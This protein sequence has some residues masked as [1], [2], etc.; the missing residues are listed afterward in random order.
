M[1]RGVSGLQIL[2]YYLHRKIKSDIC[3]H[4]QAYSG[5]LCQWLV[6]T[7]VM[8]YGDCLHLVL[9]CNLADL[10]VDGS[11]TANEPKCTNRDKITQRWSGK[12]TCLGLYNRVNTNVAEG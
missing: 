9:A 4:I 10:K 1:G 8:T 5:K 6:T 7:Q 11:I 12:L 2:F 3:E